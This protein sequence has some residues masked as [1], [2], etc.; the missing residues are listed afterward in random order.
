MV[1]MVIIIILILT[2]I[3]ADVLAP[4]TETHPGY[5]LMNWRNTF[6]LPSRDHP[7]GT[8]WAGRDILSRIIHGSRISLQVGFVVVGIA[9]ILGIILGAVSG[10]YGGIADNII[11]RIV[12]IILA[13]PNILL[14][15]SLAAALGPGLV[16]VMI[17]VGVGTVPAFA[18]VVRAS[19]LTLRE[20]EFVEAARAVGANDIRIIFRHILPNCLA[21]IIVQ[22]TLAMAGAILSAAGLSFLGLG[23]ERPKPEWGTMLNE[24]QADFLNYWH[25]SVFPGLAIVIVVLALNMMGDGLRDAFDPRLKK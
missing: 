19:V 24:A 9:M 7:L 2:A 11:M 22:A 25:I 13:I 17:A 21:P 14:A 18:R 5:N 20:Q 1:G 6:E 16:N 10:F 3:F 12:D 23:I 4:G 15:I 8:D